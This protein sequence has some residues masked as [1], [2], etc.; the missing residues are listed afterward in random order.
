MKI[1][2]K[3]LLLPAFLLMFQLALNA[4]SSPPPPPGH[5]DPGNQPPGGGAPI[6]AGA[7]FLLLMAAGYGGKKVYDARKKLAE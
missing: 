6:G 7:G 5:G 4:Q 2:F 3:V 1:L